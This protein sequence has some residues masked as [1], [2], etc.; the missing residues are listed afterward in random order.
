MARRRQS[1]GLLV[2]LITIPYTGVSIFIAVTRLKAKPAGAIYVNVIGPEAARWGWPVSTPP[3]SEPWPA[4]TQFS[5]WRSFGYRRRGAWSS[6]G[7]KTTHQMEV[8]DYGWPMA[9]VQRRQ[10]WR[11]WNAPKWN[12]VV[13]NDSGYQVRWVRL[14][15]NIALLSAVV[16]V[17]WLIWS[18]LFRMMR[19]RR[20][21]CIDC[22]YDLRGTPVS[23]LG[24]RC[25]ECGEERAGVS[26]V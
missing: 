9:V 23:G 25:P 10:H 12:T 20:G 3:D 2:I 19:V 15:I 22:G 26:A 13:P 24:A 16:C 21:L 4:V 17:P 18:R 6:E 1:L 8:D 7:G 11:P 5:E 14:F